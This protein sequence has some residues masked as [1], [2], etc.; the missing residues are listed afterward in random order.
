M[1]RISIVKTEK[2]SREELQ[3]YVREAL[4]SGTELEEILAACFAEYADFLHNTDANA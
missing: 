3:R 2:K 4:Y 1:E